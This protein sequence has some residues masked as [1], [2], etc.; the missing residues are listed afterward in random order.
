MI[1]GVTGSTPATSAS[2]VM[3]AAISSGP[4]PFA[5][6]AEAIAPA[7]MPQKMSMSVTERVCRCALSARSTPSS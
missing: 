7:L 6:K 4:M 2:P 1:D 3:A 5:R